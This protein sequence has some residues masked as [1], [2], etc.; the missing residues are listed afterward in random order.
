MKQEE[1]IRSATAYENARTACGKHEPERA[2]D[3]LAIGIAGKVAAARQI[4]IRPV[5]IDALR[6]V[7]SVPTRRARTPHHSTSPRPQRTRGQDCPQCSAGDCSRA[8]LERALRHAARNGG[9]AVY[10]GGGGSER[11]G[12]CVCDN[13]NSS[14]AKR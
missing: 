6:L 3:K 14:G 11:A 9:R 5:K 8:S 7:D 10:C 2:S 13:T 4:V 12:S 1:M